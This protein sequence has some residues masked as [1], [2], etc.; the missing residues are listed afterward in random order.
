M[1]LTRLDEDLMHK[2]HGVRRPLWNG[3][4]L[5]VTALGSVT[6]LTLAVLVALG[7]LARRRDK[8]GLVLVSLA[9]LGAIL[10]TIGVKA[11][12]ARPRPDLVPHLVHVTSASYPSG[13]ALATA[14]IYL[15]LAIAFTRR[16]PR[17]MVRASAMTT[18]IALALAVA[19]TRVYLGVHYPTDVV[20]GSLFGF[21]WTLVWASVA[22][23]LAY[24]RRVRPTVI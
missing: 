12:A 21:G 22:D 15:A 14:S 9:V 13:H 10:G 5:D 3:F 4:A 18:A 7:T 11:L 23:Y 16:D 17:V 24:R 20:A 6:L 19:A 8:G 2:V 1:R